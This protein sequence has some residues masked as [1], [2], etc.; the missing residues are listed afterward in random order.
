MIPV[1]ETE[2][3]ILRGQRLADF[4]AQLALWTDPRTVRYFG[5]QPHTEEDVWQRF[6]RNHGQWSLFGFGNWVI[7]EKASH[8]TIGTIGFFLGKRPFEGPWRDDPEAG[9]AIAPD[10]QGQGF[11]REAMA[12]AIGWADANMT[13]SQTW[14]MINQGNEISVKV[15]ARAGYR[16]FGTADYKGSPMRIF[17][18]S[19]GHFAPPAAPQS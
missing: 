16:A 7:E 1:L 3:L 4:P 15:A 2:R 17:T 9:W 8:C 12:A 18:R 10:S 6:L 11:A 19:R 5:G 14:C 13:A